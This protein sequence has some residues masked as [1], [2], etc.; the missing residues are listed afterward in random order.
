M[1]KSTIIILVALVVLI[2]GIIII[3][4]RKKQQDDITQWPPI[5]SNCPDYFLNT[6]ANMCKNPFKLGDPSVCSG[7]LDTDEIDF[8]KDDNIQTEQG[9]QNICSRIKK[10]GLSWEGIDDT[11][12]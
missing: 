2:L 9:K 4:I 7:I 6:N 5:I 11:C 3:Y 8:I 10:C 12:A 1:E